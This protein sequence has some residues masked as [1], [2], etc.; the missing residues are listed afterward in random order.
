MEDV[1]WPDRRVEKPDDEKEERAL[2]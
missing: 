1:G 2:E